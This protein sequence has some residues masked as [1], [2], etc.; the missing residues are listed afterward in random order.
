M[1][2]QRALVVALIFTVVVGAVVALRRQATAL[3]RQAAPPD[4]KVAALTTFNNRS[5]FVPV[6]ER[7]RRFRFNAGDKSPEAYLR[8]RIPDFDPTGYVLKLKLKASPRVLGTCTM[9]S[10][11]GSGAKCRV[12]GDEGDLAI[13]MDPVDQ[14]LWGAD[15]CCYVGVGFQKPALKDGDEVE[16]VDFKFE[17]K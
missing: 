6:A 16:L 10:A 5:S 12:K 17:L 13:D 2:M 4:P 3:S 9:R 8:F 11:K 14:F 7:G 1:N 15:H